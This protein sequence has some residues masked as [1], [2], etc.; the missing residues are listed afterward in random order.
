MSIEDLDAVKIEGFL[1]HMSVWGED[2]EEFYNYI[3]GNFYFGHDLK[4]EHDH[5]LDAGLAL[6]VNIKHNGYGVLRLTDEF[7]E[8][9]KDYRKMA[10]L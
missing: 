10:K 9:L 1:R 3:E 8:Y 7:Q 4:E 5:L 2:G 6:S